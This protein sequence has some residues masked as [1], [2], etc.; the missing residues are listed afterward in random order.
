MKALSHPNFTVKSN[1]K[2]ITNHVDKESEDQGP[3]MIQ[4]L[5]AVKAIEKYFNGFTIKHIPRALNDEADKLAKGSSQKTT[6]AT[7]CLL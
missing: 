7:G 6:I 2:V 3:K 1:S 4:Y 5:E